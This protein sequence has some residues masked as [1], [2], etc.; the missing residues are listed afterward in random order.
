MYNR[1]VV[2]RRADGAVDTLNTWDTLML[3]PVLPGF[4]CSVS[5]IFSGLDRLAA[6][7]MEGEGS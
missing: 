1:E 3:D 6:M 4:S 5:D 7:E 2:I